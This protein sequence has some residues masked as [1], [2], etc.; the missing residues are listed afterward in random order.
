MTYLHSN[1][2]RSILLLP[3]MGCF[4]Q[5]VAGDRKVQQIKLTDH[6]HASITGSVAR[7]LFKTG[8]NYEGKHFILADGIRSEWIP[9]IAGYDVTLVSRGDI[10]AASMPI[11]Y[12][13]V[14]LRALRQS[15]HV[16]V[17]GYDSET[18]DLFHGELHYSFRRAGNRWR[19][20]YLG[21]A[22]D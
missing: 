2:I 13:V 9:K 21:G 18:K 4:A 10:E 6:D 3:A 1:R 15:V 19:G 16:T 22:G 17:T 11:F 5:A 12:Y 7:D 20:K 8:H 14:Q